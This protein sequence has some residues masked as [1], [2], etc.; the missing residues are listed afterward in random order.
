MVITL[1]IGT[2]TWVG[3]IVAAIAIVAAIILK[4]RA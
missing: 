2:W 3:L 4:K 1:A